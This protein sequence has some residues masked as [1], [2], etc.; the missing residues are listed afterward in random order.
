MGWKPHRACPVCGMREAA[1]L[2]RQQFI[3]PEDYTLPSEQ[4]ICAC[5]KC[6]AVYGDTTATP[7]SE[8]MPTPENSPTCRLSSRTAPGPR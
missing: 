4:E 3:V 1:A 7:L 6:G 5:E 8:P 2:H